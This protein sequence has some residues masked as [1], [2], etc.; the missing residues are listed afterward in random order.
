M[1]SDSGNSGASS[2][3]AELGRGAHLASIP[4]AALS[5]ERMGPIPCDASST[6]PTQLAIGVHGGSEGPT[7][8]KRRAPEGAIRQPRARVPPEAASVRHRLERKID[9]GPHRGQGLRNRRET[10][11]GRPSSVCARGFVAGAAR[12]VRRPCAARAP[13]ALRASA[14]LGRPS[15]HPVPLPFGRNRASAAR[16]YD[17]RSARSQESCLPNPRRRTPELATN[18]EEGVGAG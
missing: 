9:V 15:T 3:W 8:P 2:P 4:C 18:C 12:E 16:S 17:G 10:R 5:L 7:R 1:S 6:M 14:T 11:H 13:L